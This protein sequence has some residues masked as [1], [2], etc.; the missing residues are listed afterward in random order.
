MAFRAAALRLG[1]AP[2]VTVQN[3]YSLV[4]R[5]TDG[6]LA[7]VLF[8]EQVSLLAYS[9]LAGGMLSG[10]Y[11][12]AAGAPDGRFNRFEGF[13]PRFR[14]PLVAEAV[15]AYVALARRRGLSPVELALGYVKSRFF[16]AATILGATTLAQL[17]EDIA[18]V[19]VE[20]D[21]AT[22]ADVREIQLR[23]PNPAA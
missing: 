5:S 11:L 3:S 9:P 20:L 7:E 2:P 16:T 19:A 10:K 1:V 8:R 13:S 21:E 14:K 23:Y 6:D 17:R 12:D 18:A 4:S 15:A 22:L